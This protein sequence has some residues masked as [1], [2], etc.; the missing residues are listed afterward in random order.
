MLFGV[1]YYLDKC[2]NYLSNIFYE[3][4]ELGIINNIRLS[5]QS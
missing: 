2:S 5:K 1:L 4:L 3:R